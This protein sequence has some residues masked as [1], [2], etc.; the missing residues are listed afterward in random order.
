M[1]WNRRQL[2]QLGGAALAAGTLPA[3][4]E[5]ADT[6]SAIIKPKRLKEGDVVGLI[7]PA[8]AT[9]RKQRAEIARENMAALGLRVQFG[10]H[11]FDRYG[12]LGGRDEDRAADINHFFG[13]SEVRAVLAQGGG[14]G[15]NRLLPLL[16][17]DL[18]RKNPKIVMGFSDITGLLLGIHAKTGLVTFHGQ[19]GGSSWSEFSTDYAKRLIFDGEAVTM[20]N[21]ISEEDRLVQVENRVLTI[22]SGTARGRLIGG[23]LTILTTLMGSDYL[24]DFNGCILFVEDLNEQVYR[25]DR[26][27]TQLKLAG[28]LDRIAGFVFGR[29]T[30][31]DP[32]DGYG[33]LTLEQV[34]DDHV[35]PLGI[36]AWYGSMI[37][38]IK[39]QFTVP[40]GIEAEIDADEGTIK[41]LES[42]VV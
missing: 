35:A 30:R 18:I 37:G 29:C 23:N 17:Y 20:R 8:S 1:D 4:A 13:D 14:W 6:G 10:D 28:V 27:L 41:L 42:A 5:P 16:D 40:L 11:L 21:R 39:H 3:L 22:T 33:S 36:P 19:T 31:C 2:L 38:H 7:S 12:S 26:M 34:F 24:P 15:C 9:F 32:G 25:I